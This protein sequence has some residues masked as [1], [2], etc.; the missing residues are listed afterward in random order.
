LGERKVIYHDKTLS[1]EGIFD[2]KGLFRTIVKWYWDNSYF[3]FEKDSA[4]FV[5]EDGKQ[6]EYEM[7]PYK[8]ITDFHRLE[9]QL[10][11]NFRQL[12]EVDVELKG[13]KYRLFK[14]R[15][16]FTFDAIL[17]TDFENKWES[18][19]FFFLFRVLIDKLIMKSS[20]SAY[21]ALVVKDAQMLEEEIKAYLN[22]FRFIK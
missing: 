10:K 3:Y 19:P 4:E 11:A 22:M 12:K 6:I 1:Y 14:G 5:Y 20:T 16:D 9:I 2:P 7:I 17:I 15:A 18:R 21:E 8:K 13:V